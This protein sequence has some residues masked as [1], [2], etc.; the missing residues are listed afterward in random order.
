MATLR[1]EGELN[2]SDLYKE[3]VNN[4]GVLSYN[5][6]KEVV[7]SFI[8]KILDK[9]IT[10]GYE[11]D[12]PYKCGLLKVIQLERMVSTKEDGTLKGAIDWGNTNKL[13]AE[14]IERGEVPLIVYK[15]ENGNKTGNNGGVPYLCY[16]TTKTYFRW[17]WTGNAGMHNF[18]KYTFDITK[19]NSLLLCK[20][21]ND[22]SYLLFKLRQRNGNNKD[23]LSKIFASAGS[24]KV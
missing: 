8:K 11:F 23:Y 15:D 18:L 17:M 19:D 13:K 6:Y 14:I 24:V 2:L 10:T 12:M 9:I 5:K 7:T 22:N 16:H 3:Y 4:G 21:I 20:S 1:K